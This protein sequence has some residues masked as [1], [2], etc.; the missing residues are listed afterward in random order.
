MVEYSCEDAVQELRRQ[1]LQVKCESVQGP[2]GHTWSIRSVDREYY[3]STKH[4]LHLKAH[5]K[6]SIEG[7]KELNK[8]LEKN[9][10]R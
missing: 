1:G 6:L 10:T 8:I 7:I 9:K 2:E 5:D 3:V 4:L